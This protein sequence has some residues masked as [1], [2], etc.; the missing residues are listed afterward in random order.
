MVVKHNGAKDM[1]INAF[2][3]AL[4][5]YLALTLTGGITG[6]CINPAVG[7]V[8]SVYQRYFNRKVFK[9][10]S[11]ISLVYVPAYVFG[12]FLGA[13]IA[14]WFQ[15]IS[16]EKALDSAEQCKEEEYGKLNN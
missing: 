10:A 12:P 8:Q 7:L 3:I 1:P 14:G 11:D 9:G 2:A 6:G 4:A 5:L 16:H 13:F 15:K